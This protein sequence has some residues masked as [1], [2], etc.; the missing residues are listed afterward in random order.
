MA[1]VEEQ[2]ADPGKRPLQKC[3]AKEITTMVHSAEDYETAV[4]ASQMLFGNNTAEILHKLDE[5]TLLAVLDGVPQYEVPRSA[6]D[7]GTKLADMLVDLAPVF[8]SKGELRKLAQQGGFSI[9][10]EKVQD[11]YA[12]VET[13]MLL[14]NK[15][16]LAQQ[17]K[18]K[19][20]LIV[21]KD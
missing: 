6:I 8:P 18:K 16:I 5:E 14:N 21:V 9:N 17:G 1:L 2:K 7:E 15:Y 20:H 19:Y 10:K 3:L 13:G 12:P 4:E 11:V